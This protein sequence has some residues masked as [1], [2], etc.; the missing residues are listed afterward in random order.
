MTAASQFIAQLQSER[1]GG[2]ISGGNRA[3]SQV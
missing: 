1:T 2:N 3:K